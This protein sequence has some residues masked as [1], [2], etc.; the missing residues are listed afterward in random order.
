MNKE[1]L[2]N[3]LSQSKSSILGKYIQELNAN[4][5]ELIDDTLK[6]CKSESARIS[7]AMAQKWCKWQTNNGPVLMPDKVRL[8]YRRGDTEVVLQEHSPQV[9]HIKFISKLLNESASDPK[10]D[11]S[12]HSFSLALPYINFIYVFK[13]GVLDKTMITFCDRPLKTL[14]EKPMKPYLSNI[15]D[16]MK[17]CHGAAYLRESL[18][19]NNITQQISYTLDVFWQTVYLDEWSSNFWA[20]KSYFKDK[21]P[22]LA[23]LEAWQEATLENPLFVI[24]NVEW[25][26]YND[27]DDYGSMLASF[28][29]YDALDTSFQQDVFQELSNQLFDEF[30]TE[31]NSKMNA[32]KDEL[33]FELEKL[34]DEFLKGQNNEN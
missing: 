1:N 27:F 23:T 7:W 19:P 11:S 4:S 6:K 18:I 8:Y 33:N 5:E 21:D 26:P 25:I 17:L 14:E 2:V 12:V 29:D 24:E 32:L 15:N 30:K 3:F 20:Y 9:R 13:K 10:T 31:F 28:F 34:V 16:A 22:R